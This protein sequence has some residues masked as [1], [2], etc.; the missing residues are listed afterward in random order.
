MKRIDCLT[1]VVEC[2]GRDVMD[3]DH[4]V[5]VEAVGSQE[6]LVCDVDC[7]P[8]DEGLILGGPCRQ[9]TEPSGHKPFAAVLAGE[10][11]RPEAVTRVVRDADASVMAGEGVG[12]A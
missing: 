9:G 4:P 7:Q 10:Q 2:H 11:P 5:P 6:I 3:Q 8:G 12:H 1:Y